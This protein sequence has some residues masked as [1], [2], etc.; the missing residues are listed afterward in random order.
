MPLPAYLAFQGN[1]CPPGPQQCVTW[2]INM[3][4]DA[5]ELSPELGFE[6]PLSQRPVPLVDTCVH[7]TFIDVLRTPPQ[8]PLALRADQA[9]HHHGWAMSQV[10][11]KK[12]VNHT[13]E[14]ILWSITLASMMSI[15]DHILCWWGT[16]P[17]NKTRFSFYSKIVLKQEH[18]ATCLADISITL[19]CITSI[20]M[21]RCDGYIWTPPWWRH[22]PAKA[23]R[24]LS[25][26]S[27]KRQCFDIQTLC[28]KRMRFWFQCVAKRWQPTLTAVKCAKW[29]TSTLSQVV[30]DMTG[31]DKTVGLSPRPTVARAVAPCL[32]QHHKRIFTLWEEWVAPLTSYALRRCD[33]VTSDRIERCCYC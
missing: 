29:W 13:T 3:D 7:Q 16:H 30:F 4:I 27:I 14:M 33:T 31:Q 11:D 17:T 10:S 12:L 19:R 20:H 1:S 9:T 23:M 5:K 15:F 2:I 28:P 26:N 25:L 18:I 24:I 6:R 22:L 8:N 32:R 21:R